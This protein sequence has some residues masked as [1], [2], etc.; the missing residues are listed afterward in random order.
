MKSVPLF[1]MANLL[2][3]SLMLATCSWADSLGTS[4]MQ[5]NEL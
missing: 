5:T 3:S 1:V 4:N 2:C